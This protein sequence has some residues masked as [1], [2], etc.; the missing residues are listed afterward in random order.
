MNVST[1]KLS[2]GIPITIALLIVA[3]VGIALTYEHPPVN[4]TQQGY[5]GTGMTQVSNPR[6]VEALV[7][8]NQVPKP[9]PA[10]PPGGPRAGTIYQNVHVLGDLSVAQFTRVMQAMTNW[11]SPDEG[12]TYCHAAGNFAKDSLY[13][14]KVARR[15]LKMTRNINSAWKRHVGRTGVTCY[16][17][18][19]GRHVP[20]QVWSSGA[21]IAGD[22]FGPYSQGTGMDRTRAGQ[23]APSEA[24][25]SASLPYD[26]F[27]PFLARGD[28]I[29]VVSTAA[30][31]G[32]NPDGIKAAESTYSLMMHMSDSLG[33]NCTYCHN[34]RSFMSWGQSSP[35]RVAAYHGI[36]MVRDVNSGYIS[37]LAKVFPA[38][39][40]G[41]LGDVYKVN[42][43]TCHQ[44]ASK[45]LLGAR[46]LKDYP[47]L[48]AS[49]QQQPA[50]A[51]S[52]QT[53]PRKVGGPK[54]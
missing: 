8:A 32:T 53:D 34:S 6:T 41:P 30:L 18:H 25:A 35:R 54:R 42:C 9:L 29:R 40:K 2:I 33:V 45:P 16:T 38:H 51:P 21:V 44:G 5:R 7:A 23:N 22:F 10:A 48:S 11:V 43:A 37:S 12:C 17:C 4:S 39:R 19:R 3:A 49:D 47:E 36:R 50:A 46:M 14:K 31:P 27:T 13:T 28:D 15:M 52:R 1:S 26:P 20:A 24:A